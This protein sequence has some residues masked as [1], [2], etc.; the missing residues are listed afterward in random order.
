MDEWRLGL[1]GDGWS[2]GCF[3]VRSL[4]YGKTSGKALGKASAAYALLCG[5]DVVFEAAVADLARLGVVDDIRGARVA[6][7][8]LADGTDLPFLAS[9]PS[10]G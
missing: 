1:G 7:A 9:M 6:V 3:R 4:A 5:L 8:R 10:K 2:A